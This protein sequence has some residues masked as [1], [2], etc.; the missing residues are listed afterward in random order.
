[1]TNKPDTHSAFQWMKWFPRDFAS[2]TRL[3][4]LAARAVYRELLDLQWDVGGM[5]PGILPDD[6]QQLREL[7]RAS[8]AEW[9]VAWPLV[10]PKFPTVDGGRQNARLEEH[11]QAAV[12]E[13]QT[14][15]RGAE[16]TNRK[17]W[18]DGS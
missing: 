6:E 17:R 2:S 15:R 1:M 14:R 7:V 10:E 11:R 9:K 3:W 4:P 12:K 13:Y 8:A 5:Q 16:T 18:G